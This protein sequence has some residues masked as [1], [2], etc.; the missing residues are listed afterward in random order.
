MIV[1]LYLGEE[2]VIRADDLVA[3]IDLKQAS[4]EETIDGNIEIL[5]HDSTVKSLVITKYKQYYSSISATTLKKK[6]K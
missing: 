2:K 5:D 3:I 1:Y 4:A 6:F